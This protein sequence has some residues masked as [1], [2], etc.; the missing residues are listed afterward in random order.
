MPSPKPEVRL[1]VIVERP[2]AGV[3]YALQ[4]GRGA[5]YTPTQTQ[6]SEGRDL[7]FDFVV[8]IAGADTRA[9]ATPDFTGPV[10]LGP[11]GG[12]FVY[13][14]IGTFAGQANTPWSRRLKIPL[15][16]ITRGLIESCASDDV[17]ETRVPGTGKDG[18]PTCATVKPFSG[19]HVARITTERSGVG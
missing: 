4:V 17:L 11:R 7:Q 2:P 5:N 16:G 18:G 13:L 15:T 14:D 9:V 1:R 6:R 3:D 19:W 12:R 10:V 8:S